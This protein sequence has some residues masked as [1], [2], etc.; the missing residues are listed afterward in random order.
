MDS[1]WY[2]WVGINSYFTDIE[3]AQHNSKMDLII[4][5]AISLRRYMN[6][7]SK[8]DVNLPTLTHGIQLTQSAMQ[9]IALGLL[10]TPS[11]RSWV[12]NGTKAVRYFLILL[13]VIAT[14]LT[15]ILN[16]IETWH[17]T[18]SVPVKL[19]VNVTLDAFLAAIWPITWILW[20]VG[21]W[22]GY[23]TPLS[24]LG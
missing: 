11:G 7:I 16:V 24:L 8:Y 4:I 22:L 17:G 14:P 23:P 3:K 19:L 20:V 15:F 5:F 18:A 1:I 12:T 13:A 10:F 6:G 9:A 21:A 2:F